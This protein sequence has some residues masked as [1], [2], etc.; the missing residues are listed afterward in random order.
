MARNAPIWH[1]VVVMITY[2]KADYKQIW[3]ALQR[4]CNEQ[5]K[6]A[7][8]YDVSTAYA[9]VAVKMSEMLSR[10]LNENYVQ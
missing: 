7:L 9:R 3:F 4:W 6:N 10:G 1:W 2:R 8:I 5:S